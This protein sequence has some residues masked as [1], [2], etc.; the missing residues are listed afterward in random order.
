MFINVKQKLS[1]WKMMGPKVGGNPWGTRRSSMS[2][3]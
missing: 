1:F 3:F 2:A